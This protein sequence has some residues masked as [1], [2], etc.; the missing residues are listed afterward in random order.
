MDGDLRLLVQ[1]GALCRAGSSA[2]QTWNRSSP[3][4]TSSRPRRSSP[5]PYMSSGRLAPVD[6]PRPA[7][8][9]PTRCGIC[10][11]R[12]G[13]PAAGAGMSGPGGEAL[14]QGYLT[15]PHAAPRPG[16]PGR[17][18]RRPW[19]EGSGLIVRSQQQSG[20]HRVARLVPIPAVEG[21]KGAALTVGGS[22]GI[23]VGRDP[24]RRPSFLRFLASW[25]S[26]LRIGASGVGL[27]PNGALPR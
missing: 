27:R 25:W 17:G 15:A 12:C 13:R 5:T 3:T 26:C 7:R 1:Q 16:R 20:R 4:S 9:A 11:A 22:S 6:I 18:R 2:H 19:S 21:G 8:A 14:F 24:R 10:Q 23:A